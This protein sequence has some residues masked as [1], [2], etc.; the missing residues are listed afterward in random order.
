MENKEYKLREEIKNF[1]IK[2]Y[3]CDINIYS[4]NINQPLVL[5]KGNVDIKDNGSSVM[6]SDIIESKGTNRIFENGNIVVSNYNVI[7]SNGVTIVNGREVM[8]DEIDNIELIIP[9]KQKNCSIYAK[10]ISGDTSVSDLKLFRFVLETVGGDISLK[11]FDS[12]HSIIKTVGGD[13]DI[14]VLESMLNYD[15]DANT[16]CGDKIQRSIEKESPILLDCKNY[17]R[18]NTVSGDIKVLFKGKH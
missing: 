14:E 18:I 16:L 12:I 6:I 3:I 5:C 15:V 2:T 4:D 8:D 13:V 11:N 9:K 10:N 1:Q 7:S 17:L